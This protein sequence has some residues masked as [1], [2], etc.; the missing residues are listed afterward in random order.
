[1]TQPHPDISLGELLVLLT[2]REI[3]DRSLLASDATILAILDLAPVVTGIDFR[4]P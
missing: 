4:L 1:M 3:N 2:V